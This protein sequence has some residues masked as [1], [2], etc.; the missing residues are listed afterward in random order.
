[1]LK[2]ILKK[3]SQALMS[4]HSTCYVTTPVEELQSKS[5]AGHAGNT[6]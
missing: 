6:Y 2:N 3:K 5:A 1:V 4:K